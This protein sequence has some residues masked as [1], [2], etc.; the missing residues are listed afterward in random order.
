MLITYFD[1]VKHQK[2]RP[3]CWLGALVADAEVV[4]HLE[5]QVDDISEEFF[6]RRTP[7]KETEFH[8]AAI[9]NGHEH[10]KGWVWE[11]SRCS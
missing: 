9:F 2:G 5:R 1:E 7:C 6:G 11:K 4:W 8:A 3:F 10:F